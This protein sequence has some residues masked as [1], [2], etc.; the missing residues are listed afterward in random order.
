MTGGKDGVRQSDDTQ[1]FDI[2]KGRWVHSKKMC[3]ARSHHSSCSLGKNIY[4]F[5]GR[6]YQHTMLNSIEWLDAEADASG[7]PAGWI[8]I[9]VKENV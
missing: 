4:M 8:E 6:N 5:C 7:K 9:P 2:M 1:R 3:T